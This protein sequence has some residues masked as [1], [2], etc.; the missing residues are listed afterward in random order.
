MQDEKLRQ[1]QSLIEISQERS[2]RL[3]DGFPVGYVTLSA[4]GSIL[5]ANLPALALLGRERPHLMGTPFL[6]C[7]TRSDSAKFLGHLRF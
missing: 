3:Y 6:F 7:V 5:E 4:R 1:L 2:A